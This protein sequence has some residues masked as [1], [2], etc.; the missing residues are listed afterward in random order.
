MV[1]RVKRR[2][3]EE[4]DVEPPEDLGYAEQR[5]AVERLGRDPLVQRRA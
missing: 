3:A 2:P 5:E 4:D 1:T